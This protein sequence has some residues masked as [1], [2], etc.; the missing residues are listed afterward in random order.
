MQKRLS[1]I[2]Y[3]CTLSVLTFIHVSVSLYQHSI[4]PPLAHGIISFSNSNSILLVPPKTNPSK[5][6]LQGLLS[7]RVKTLLH[8]LADPTAVAAVSVLEVLADPL[9]DIGNLG[10][11]VA[12]C[13][14]ACVELSEANAEPNLVDVRIGNDVVGSRRD[15]W[16]HQELNQALGRQ[17]PALGVPVDKGL[18]VAERLGE[19]HDCR[20]AV[21]GSRK[22]LRV[23]KDDGQVDGFEY[24]VDVSRRF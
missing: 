2:I 18:R 6:L 1:P 15:R 3:T 5:V 9:P 10:E 8:Q 7:L 23:G 14:L 21:G 12:R 4:S 16:V 22:F 13:L 19:G 17:A 20:L 24:A 11:G